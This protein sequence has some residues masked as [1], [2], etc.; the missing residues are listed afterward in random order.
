MD[1]ITETLAHK[2]LHISFPPRP[3]LDNA[4][5]DLTELCGWS[6]QS[7]RVTVRRWRPTLRS[8]HNFYE[9]KLLVDQLLSVR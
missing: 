9:Q 3:L 5:R 8:T 4:C 6:C 1:R 7:Q 2:D